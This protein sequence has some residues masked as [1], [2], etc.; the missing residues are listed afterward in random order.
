MDPMGGLM[1]LSQQDLLLAP[2]TIGDGRWG[3][4]KANGHAWQRD[5]RC[6]AKQGE[7]LKPRKTI[8]GF[9]VQLENVG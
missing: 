9:K 6:K 8:A 3:G 1:L 5:P 7:T 2:A 4:L